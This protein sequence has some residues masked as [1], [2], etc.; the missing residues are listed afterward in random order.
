MFFKLFKRKVSR[1][2][3]IKTFPG[4]RTLAHKVFLVIICG[5]ICILIDILL[6][7]DGKGLDQPACQEEW[8]KCRRKR[9]IVMRMWC[10]YMCAHMSCSSI[11]LFTCTLV[12]SPPDSME[13]IR[14]ETRPVEI[15]SMILDWT[16]QQNAFSESEARKRLSLSLEQGHE[17]S[18]CEVLQEDGSSSMHSNYYVFLLYL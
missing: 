13:G 1:D 2:F 5:L 8:K 10:I 18:I 17:G 16:W 6:V 7:S 3:F 12:R 9:R 14:C 11:M 4:P 15:N